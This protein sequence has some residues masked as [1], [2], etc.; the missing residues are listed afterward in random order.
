M[1]HESILKNWKEARI[2]TFIL[3][4]VFLAIH[5]MMRFTEVTFENIGTYLV[6]FGALCIVFAIFIPLGAIFPLLIYYRAYVKR[7]TF[8]LLLSKYLLPISL[9]STF[10]AMM[11]SPLVGFSLLFSKPLAGIIMLGSSIFFYHYMKSINNYRLC[12]RALLDA[13]RAFRSSKK[14]TS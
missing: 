3:S 1:D 13:N 10:I 7:G 9:L 8:L 2:N 14:T 4:Q 5:L 6:A 12:C 11:L